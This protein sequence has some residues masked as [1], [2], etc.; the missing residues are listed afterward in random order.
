M[1][2][3]TEIVESLGSLLQNQRGERAG[4]YRRV[5]IDSR[6][7]GRG[8]LF[9]ALTVGRGDGHD[10]AADAIADVSMPD[11]DMNADIHASAAYRAH[12]VGV[13]ARRAVGQAAG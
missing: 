12:L 3:T 6:Q 13:M 9:V 8:D 5:V 11:A 10:F 7:A 4:R 1:I 2:E